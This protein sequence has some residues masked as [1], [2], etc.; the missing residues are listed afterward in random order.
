[1]IQQ[2]EI[3]TIKKRRCAVNVFLKLD[4]LSNGENFQ[5]HQAVYWSLERGEST[6]VFISQVPQVVAKVAR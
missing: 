3:P 1:M 2:N 5:I 4:H 6:T